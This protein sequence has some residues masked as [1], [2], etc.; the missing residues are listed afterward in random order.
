MA[1]FLR[2]R[3]V[4]PAQ[5]GIGLNADFTQLLGRV[6]GRFGFELACRGNPRHIAQVDKGAVVRSQL[7]AELTY[8]FQERQRFNV[9]DGASNLDNGHVHCVSCAKTGS[10]FDEILNFIG[11]MRNDL[12]C[13]AKVVAPAFF[14]KH[15]FVN[16][17][18]CEV[19]GLFHARLDKTLI[20]TQVEVS[21]GTVIGDKYFTMLERRHGARVDVQIGIEFDKSD[22]EASRFQNRSKRG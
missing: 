3:P 7:Q 12:Y 11:D 8:R 9:A 14:L 13:L 16:L 4:S 15:A 18:R 5:Q 20:V 22:F 6:L 17:A 1:L 21:L 10:T 2:D 19:V